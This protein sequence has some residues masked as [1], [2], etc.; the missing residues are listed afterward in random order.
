MFVPNKVFS[1][2]L[3]EDIYTVRVKRDNI[4][5]FRPSVGYGDIIINVEFTHVL[6]K[7]SKHFVITKLPRAGSVP[8]GLLQNAR[9]G[10]L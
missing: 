3:P 4:L 6:Y 9:V 10:P 8:V 7:D 5:Y 1:L 2:L